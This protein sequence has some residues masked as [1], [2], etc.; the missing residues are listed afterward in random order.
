[1]RIQSVTRRLPR[2]RFRRE[3]GG[4]ARIC[5]VRAFIGATHSGNT[6]AIDPERRSTY[7]TKWDAA[8][9]IIR[10]Q[11]LRFTIWG[12]GWRIASRKGRLDRTSS[13]LHRY[14]DSGSGC[15]SYT[16][17]ERLTWFG[18]FGHTMEGDRRPVEQ[19]AVSTC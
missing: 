8:C 4:C 3:C 6:H 18:R 9:A 13:V 16:T 17:D 1:M 15:S 5:H 7:S 12:G 14:G 11:I 19:F 2:R 10:I